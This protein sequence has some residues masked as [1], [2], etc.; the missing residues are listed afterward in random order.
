MRSP[1]KKSFLYY[2]FVIIVGR[3]EPDKY[4]EGDIPLDANTKRIRART[5]KN[6]KYD[7]IASLKWPTNVIPYVFD[8][9]LSK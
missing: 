2:F 3:K 7:K 5:D 8:N 6:T 9:A 4:V 1:F